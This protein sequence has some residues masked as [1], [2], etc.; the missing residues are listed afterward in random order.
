MLCCN[1]QLHTHFQ[2]M[3]LKTIHNHN[4]EIFSIL[5]N[6]QLA[7]LFTYELHISNIVAACF[8]QK[9]HVTYFLLPRDGHRTSVEF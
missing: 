3:L 9:T 8:E 5:L 2:R 4:K 1:L 7:A 6:H